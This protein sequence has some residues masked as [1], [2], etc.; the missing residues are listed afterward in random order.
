MVEEIAFECIGDRR[1]AR[2]GQSGQKQCGRA[3]SEASLPLLRLDRTG[4][5]LQRGVFGF[6]LPGGFFGGPALHDHAGTDR[7]IGDSIDHDERPGRSVPAVVVESDRLI[8]TD[9]APPD[10]IQFQTR[11]RRAMERIDVDAVPE[12]ADRSRSHRRAMFEPIG[13]SRDHRIFVHPDHDRLERVTDFGQVSRPNDH[14]ASADVDFIFECQGDRLWRESLFEF[15]IHRHDAADAGSFAR[16][17]HHHFFA[18]A[19]DARRDGPAV[20]SEIEVRAVDELNGKSE[21][22]EVAIR[23]DIDRFEEM[24][25]RRPLVPRHV[26]T[27]LDDV[28]PLER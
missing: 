3:L 27:G 16:G 15:P 24:H 12:S 2:S 7:R 4:R 11:C 22:F 26:R 20:A 19:D 10:L 5:L 25:Q 17:K 21:V 13:L 14:V 18:F 1:F 9:G 6:P 23:A 28:V 8:E